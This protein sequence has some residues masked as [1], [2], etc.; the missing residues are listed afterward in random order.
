[1]TIST[2]LK[3]ALG[4]PLTRGECIRH[5]IRLITTST[6]RQQY[7]REREKFKLVPTATGDGGHSDRHALSA[8]TDH[9]NR[10]PKP[11]AAIEFGHPSWYE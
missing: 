1:M 7:R 10:G 11:Q 6:Y 8:A 2:P 3:I 5:L 4:I 9:L